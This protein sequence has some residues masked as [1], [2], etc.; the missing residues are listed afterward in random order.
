[1][2]Y[3]K[4]IIELQLNQLESLKYIDEEYIY[5]WDSKESYDEKFRRFKPDGDA[6]RYKNLVKFKDLSYDFYDHIQYCDFI[7][8]F[9]KYR[10]NFDFSIIREYAMPHLNMRNWVQ[11]SFVCKHFNEMANIFIKQRLE[12]IDTLRIKIFNY[13]KL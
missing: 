13:T 11:M 6:P 5:P 2:E 10:D 3:K 12:N 7:V 8:S 4:Y 9:K 1:M